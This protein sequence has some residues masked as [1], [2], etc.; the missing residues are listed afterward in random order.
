[1][2]TLRFQSLLSIPSLLSVLLLMPL[3]VQAQVAVKDPWVRATVPGQKAT[4]AFMTLTAD[5]PLSLVEVRSPVAGVVELH[6]MKMEDGVMRMRAISSLN[7]PAG[8]GVPL[9]PGG[10]H[11]MLIDIKSELNPGQTVPLT[12]VVEGP[13]RQRKT[14]EVKAPVLPLNARSAPQGH[15]SHRH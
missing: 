4:G 5:S 10:H 9:S 15:G 14:I 6:E 7:L 1:M 3:A 13:D 2:I 12:L 8:T 11:V